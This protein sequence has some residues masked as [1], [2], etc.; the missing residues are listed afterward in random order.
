MSSS[1]LASSLYALYRYYF[2]LFL[3]YFVLTTLNATWLYLAPFLTGSLQVTW[4]A[5]Y[6]CA[7]DL[8]GGD[9]DLGGQP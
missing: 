1:Y 9:K 6:V 4:H 3:A 5:S 7:M 2:S 8:T